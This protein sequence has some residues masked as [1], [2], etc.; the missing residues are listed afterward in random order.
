MSA[1]ADPQQ[2][3][4]ACETPVDSVSGARMMEQL[5]Q[6]AAWTKLADGGRSGELRLAESAARVARPARN[7][8]VP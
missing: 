3:L 6:F 2:A 7:A 8:A 1:L 4:T 5:R